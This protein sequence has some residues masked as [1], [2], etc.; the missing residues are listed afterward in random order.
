MLDTETYSSRL[1]E[2]CAQQVFEDI[3]AEAVRRAKLCVLDTLGIILGAIPFN[4]IRNIV[5]YVIERSS[6]NES[7]LM[8]FSQKTSFEGA[9]Y[10][11]G[12]MAELLE[13]QDGGW[14]G[15]HPSSVIIPVALAMAE[16]FAISGKTFLTAIVAGYEVANRICGVIHPSHQMRGFT[17][18]ST[19]GTFGAAAT[20]GKILNFNK[21]LYVKSFG[22][23]GFLVPISLGETL[24]K[25]CSIK[26]VHAGEAAK[27]GIES[28]LL[29]ERG[30]TGWNNILGD[31]DPDSLGFCN[32][33]SDNPDFE[34]LTKGLG[35][36][37]TIE[38]GYFK[39]YPS[40]R[41]THGAIDAILAIMHKQQVNPDEIRKIEVK[42]FGLAAKKVGQNY[43]SPASNIFECQ[44]SLPYVTAATILSGSFGVQE[45]LPEAIK[46]KEVHD[47]AAKVS[48][49]ED[50]EFSK[51]FP[52]TRCTEVRIFLNSGKEHRGR[53]EYTKGDPEYML[54]DDEL[55]RKFRSL[56]SCVL[57]GASIENLISSVLA[58]ETISDASTIMQIVGT[59]R[60]N[61]NVF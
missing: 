42:T 30:F 37:F 60:K 49:E 27:V 38:S 46:T 23:A 26:L 18:T 40:C 36:S 59:G 39:A 12:A 17:P 1:A 47:L 50:D 22:I 61:G 24:W 53:V 5:S 11:Y 48:V 58:L 15:N 3:P 55:L 14:R 57:D 45:I 6:K 52:K 41:L 54:T 4:E 20:A 56:V 16:P 10:I 9:A 2:F 7:T 13:L 44:F 32:V 28:A 34:K 51:S 29:A 19:G 21:D 35:K 8:G 31:M 25:G 43:T 33:T